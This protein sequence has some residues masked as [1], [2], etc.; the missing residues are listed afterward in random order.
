MKNPN[1]ALLDDARN[2]DACGMS[3]GKWVASG[4]PKTKEKRAPAKA[5]HKKKSKLFGKEARSCS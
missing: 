3:Y 2:A 4:R 5:G 1:Q